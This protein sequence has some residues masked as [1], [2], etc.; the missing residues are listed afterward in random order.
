MHCIEEDGVLKPFTRDTFSSCIKSCYA[1]IDGKEYMVHKDP[2]D[3]GF[4]KSHKGLCRVIYDKNIL[5]DY[6]KCIDGYT[7]STLDKCVSDGFINFLRPVFKDGEL[8]IEKSV[9]CCACFDTVSKR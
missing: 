6:F 7:R 5:T 1:E 8:L 4:K 2:K 3:G 9:K